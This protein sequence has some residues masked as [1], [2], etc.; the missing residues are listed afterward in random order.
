MYLFFKYFTFDTKILC[1]W[2]LAMY[3][4]T[5]PFGFRANSDIAPCPIFGYEIRYLFLTKKL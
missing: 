3:K 1:V 4:K 5:S 2:A